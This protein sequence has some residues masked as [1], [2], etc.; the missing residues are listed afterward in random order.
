[1]SSAGFKLFDTALGRCGIAWGER[2]VVAVSFPETSEA[3][4]RARLLRRPASTAEAS[5]PADVQQTIDLIVALI[6]GEPSDFGAVM[7]DLEGIPEFNR[8]VYAIA[9]QIAPGE[10]RTYGEIAK[11]LGGVSESRAVGQALG[12]NPFPII[13]PCHRVLAA[14]GKTGGFSAPGGVDTKLKLL[15]IERHHSRGER[16]LFDGDDT[17]HFAAR[18]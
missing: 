10:T 17:F 6:Q 13:V 5:P 4:T 1:M 12:Q 15:S 7:L 16:T 9:R 3:K 8:R 18:K 2:G 14:N 11:Q